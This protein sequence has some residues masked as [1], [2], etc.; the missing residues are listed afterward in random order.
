MQYIMN[1]Y[2]LNTMSGLIFVGAII[3]LYFGTD[4]TDTGTNGPASSTICGYGL[5][6]IAVF[7]LLFLNI[8]LAVRTQ[9]MDANTSAFVKQMLISSS[10]AIL[11][12]IVL[13]AHIN[14]N[15]SYYDQINKGEV[16]GEFNKFT[17]LST[18]M[19][20]FQTIA[21]V[22]YLQDHVNAQSDPTV[23]ASESIVGVC[24]VLS[25]LNLI[26]VSIMKTIMTYFVTDG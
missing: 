23:S 1:R 22:K 17:T 20:I 7:I 10:P 15:V 16:P 9:E 24:A 6:A 13:I 12:F 19:T 11:T 18:L 5:M 4:T 25:M 21:L 26:F 8:S 2:V 3:K 14:L